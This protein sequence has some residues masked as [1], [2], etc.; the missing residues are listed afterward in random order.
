MDNIKEELTPQEYFDIIKGRKLRI[1]DEDLNNIYDNCMYL[2]NKY[3]STNQISGARKLMFHIDNIEKERRLL[4]LG[5]DTFVYKSD[6]E[7]YISSVEDRVIKACRIQDY[8]R[9]IP[10]DIANRINTVKN[11][12]NEIYVIYT[13]YTGE[14]ERRVSAVKRNI[15]PIVFGSFEDRDKLVIV[16]RFYFIGDWVDDYCDLTLDK[17]VSEVK[18]RTGKDIVLTIKTPEDLDELRSQLDELKPTRNFNEF[19]REVTIKTKESSTS[20]GWFKWFHKRKRE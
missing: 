11:I 14:T 1:T 4:S 10:D 12:F 5:I 20:K 19:R 13:D 3:I 17:M 9:E 15:D 6:I 2:L 8:E 16:E 18:K 7:D